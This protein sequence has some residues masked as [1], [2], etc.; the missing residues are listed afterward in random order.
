MG[1]K[2][3]EEV[4]FDD[5]L[6]GL[7]V[8]S[9]NDAAN[10]IAATVSSSVNDFVVLMN[11]RVVELGLTDTHFTSAHGHHDDDHYTTAREMA[12]IAAA[13]MQDPRVSEIASS[14]SYTLPEN[15]LRNKPL[16]LKSKTEFLAGMDSEYS[17]TYATELK[18]GTTSKAGQCFVGAAEKDGVRLISVVFM[19]TI[20]HEEPRWMDTI[21]LMDYGNSQYGQ[22]IF[23]ELYA[24]APLN[25]EV[26]NYDPND[27]QGGVLSLHAMLGVDADTYMLTGLKDDRES[28][29]RSF[30]S[31]RDVTYVHDLNAPIWSGEVIGYAKWLTKERGQ[32]FEVTLVAGRDVA[33]APVPIPEPTAVEDSYA[34]FIGLFLALI[35]TLVLLGLS[36]RANRV[37]ARRQKRRAKKRGYGKLDR[38]MRH[39]K[40]RGLKG[41][42]LI[43]GDK[44]L[45]LVEA[46]GEVFPESKYQRCIVHFYRNMLSVVPKRFMRKRTE[47]SRDHYVW[48]WHHHRFG[49]VQTFL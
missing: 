33:A 48:E 18:T 23:M 43:V 20:K 19:S 1:I 21:K 26:Q 6:Y 32:S 27:S 46:I 11:E 7:M 40:A 34:L 9:G 47:K 35:T 41:V 17:Y 29:A 28:L 3:G 15:N 14:L 31:E 37:A 13:A 39:L 16:I 10:A 4:L 36:V 38:V 44:C 30:M 22:F 8:K 5:L 42:R 24:L 49:S 25:I 12:I 45:G 2:P